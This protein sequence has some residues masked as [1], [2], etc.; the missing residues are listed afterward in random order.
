MKRVKFH[1]VMPAKKVAFG[2]KSSLF[3]TPL[4]LS[5]ARGSVLPRGDLGRSL[6]TIGE[7]TV[8]CIAEPSV[9]FDED[10]TPAN[11]MLQVGKIISVRGSEYKIVKR[12]MLVF[13][14]GLVVNRW[15]GNKTKIDLDYYAYMNLKINSTFE[16]N[17]IPYILVEKTKLS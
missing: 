7:F 11:S 12:K 6:P 15:T 2:T 8:Q 1:S 14:N 5:R 13:G 17:C 16:H 3:P 4:T 10:M 9:M